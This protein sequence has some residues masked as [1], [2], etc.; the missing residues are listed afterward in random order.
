MHYG[1]GWGACLNELL[2]LGT[3]GKIE[4]REQGLFGGHAY[5]TEELSLIS[6]SNISMNTK[7]LQQKPLGKD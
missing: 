1:N 7:L 6:G 5:V 3:R 4:R 2:S